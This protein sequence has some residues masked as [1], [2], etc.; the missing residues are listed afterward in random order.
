MDGAEHNFWVTEFGVK[1]YILTLKIG[2]GSV[3]LILTVKKIS[4]KGAFIL[5]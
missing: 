1:I 3:F 4:A 2:V 5:G